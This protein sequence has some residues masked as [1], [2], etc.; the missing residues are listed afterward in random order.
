MR[1]AVAGFAKPDQLKKKLIEQV[2]VIEVMDMLDRLFKTTLAN[3]AFA[4]KN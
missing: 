2:A 3:S 1:A 4:L